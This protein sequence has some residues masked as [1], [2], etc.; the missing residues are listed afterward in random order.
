MTDPLSINLTE[1]LAG[2]DWMLEDAR[3]MVGETYDGHTI[4]SVQ[5]VDN[6][7]EFRF[8]DGTTHTAPTD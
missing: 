2:Y 8:T 3:R 5:R 6:G 4:E 7:L 1:L